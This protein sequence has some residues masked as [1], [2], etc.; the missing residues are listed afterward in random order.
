MQTAFFGGNAGFKFR[1]SRCQ[2]YVL[3]STVTFVGCLI[4]YGDPETWLKLVG[5][6][7]NTNSL[8]EDSLNPAREAGFF[9]F[10][11]CAQGNVRDAATIMHDT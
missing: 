1:R 7:V 2:R 10:N 5:V 6:V 3:G 11:R 9:H 4:M 8:P